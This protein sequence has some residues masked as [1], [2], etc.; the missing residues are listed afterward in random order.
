MGKLL[1]SRNGRTLLAD[2]N[3]VRPERFFKNHRVWQGFSKVGDIFVVAAK[4]F[5]RSR[6]EQKRD[7]EIAATNRT[8]EKPCRVWQSRVTITL[9]RV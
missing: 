4:S 9:V 6:V 8:T 2:Y 3:T 1:V 5:S 7:Y